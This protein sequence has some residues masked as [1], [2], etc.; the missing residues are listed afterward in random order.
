MTLEISTEIQFAV[1]LLKW[2]LHVFS[3]SKLP[4]F[5]LEST[6]HPGLVNWNRRLHFSCFIQSGTNSGKKTP[7]NWPFSIVKWTISYFESN[8]A[9]SLLMRMN[10]I[11]C[12]VQILC[13]H[14]IWSIDRSGKRKAKKSL[15]TFLIVIYFCF[16]LSKPFY[17]FYSII[18]AWFYN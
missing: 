2:F 5:G 11:G 12:K 4:F 9:F 13:C 18:A 7:F 17:L 6:N 10:G 16:Q 14:I 8:A 1:P 3:L 15:C